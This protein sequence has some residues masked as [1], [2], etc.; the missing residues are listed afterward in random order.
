MVL[1]LESEKFEKGNL[2]EIIHIH[3]DSIDYIVTSNIH[4][5]GINIAELFRISWRI[6]KEGGEF[7]FSGQFSNLRVK[8]ILD[9]NQFI[10]KPLY[11]EDVRRTMSRNG[12]AALQ[13]LQN[14]ELCFLRTN[15]LPHDLKIFQTTFS[16]F[17]LD[18]LEDCEEDYDQ[19]AT[20]QG[21]APD[22]KNSFFLD[23]NN[24]FDTGE[25]CRVSGNTA[26]I[27]M[28][29]RHSKYFDVTERSD[30]RGHFSVMSTF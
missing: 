12:F 27:L 14:D 16:S 13:S 29:S 21:N 24:I 19:M 8:S 10:I 11:L 17:K 6:L 2:D 5:L 4:N 26:E 9:T 7:R 15:E 18:S 1:D 20:Y 3:D 23:L 22:Q 30:H 28:K 25:P